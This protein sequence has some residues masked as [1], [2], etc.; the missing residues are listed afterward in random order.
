MIQK[1]VTTDS[2]GSYAFSGVEQGNYLVL[3]EYD[4]ATYKVTAYQK[5]GVL[6]NVNSDVISTTIVQDGKSRLGAVTDV[7]NISNRSISNIDIGLALANTFDL[8]IDKTISKVTVQTSKGTTSENY[9]NVDLAKAE[10]AAKYLSGAT[11][12]VEY[13][14]TVSNIGDLSGYAKKIVDYIPEGM[15]FNSALEVN[16][17]WYTGLD[18]NL[19][20]D[21][22]E[23]TE[24][25]SNDSASVKL[26]L[27]KQM[28]E[29]NTGIT[30]N[31]AEIYEDYNTYGIS[32]INSTPAN[33]A[34]GE[35]DLSAADMIISVKTGEVFVYI[36]V[37][38]ITIL[39]GSI[40]IFVAYNKIVVA[41]RKGGV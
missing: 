16:S 11:V 32:D 28:T 5:E 3:F 18:G 2:K 41:K 23:N 6:E 29:E 30:N 26:V 35:N 39:L 4:T 8:K 34:Q 27:V 13:T 1:S 40:A 12:Y 36:S 37:I 17:D 9:N 31:Q 19:Y 15:T 21:V 7:I 22:L 10:I 14:I 20:T 33:K 38:I 25:K 24:I